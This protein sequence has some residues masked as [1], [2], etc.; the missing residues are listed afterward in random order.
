MKIKT[1]AAPLLA[2]AAV[3]AQAPAHADQLRDITLSYDIRLNGQYPA[4]TSLVFFN[5]YADGGTAAW[6]SDTIP[7]GALQH[8]VTDPF[9]DSHLVP[10]VDDLII[11]LV[12]DLPNDAPGQ[13]HIV[14]L[15]D[16]LAAQLSNHIAWGT[17]FRHTLEDQLISSL[18]LMTSGQSF[19]V[20]QPGIDAMFAFA[21][22]DAATGIL[23]PTGT[24]RN[25]SFQLGAVQA[26]HITTS[27]FTVMAFSDG[28][29]LG[30][31]VASLDATAVAVP[32]PGVWLL[33]L[34]GLTGLGGRGLH[35]RR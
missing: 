28:Q 2:L 26:G 30:Q 32:E 31:G 10:P 16:P 33:M 7:A 5:S 12:Q 35:R 11:G 14:M 9:D 24:P 8:F 22:G 13:K 34:A 23:G 15:M 18:E 27:A 6:W 19:E 4:I 1:L 20:I 3:L 17:L 25:A 21:Y 29:V